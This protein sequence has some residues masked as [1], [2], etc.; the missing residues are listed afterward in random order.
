[1]ARLGAEHAAILR[2]DRD[3]LVTIRSDGHKL[4]LDSMLES[5]DARA[6]TFNWAQSLGFD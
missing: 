2:T 4:S 5:G 3:G 1:V 6:D